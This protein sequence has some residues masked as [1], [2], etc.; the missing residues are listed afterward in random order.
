MIPSFPL[1]KFK[2]IVQVLVPPERVVL[3]V[4]EIAAALEAYQ[5]TTQRVAELEERRDVLLESNTREVVRRREAEA[6]ADAERAANVEKAERLGRALAEIERLKNRCSSEETWVNCDGLYVDGSHPDTPH[7]PIGTKRGERC[8]ACA[9]L[10]EL[11]VSRTNLKDA[12]SC[13]SLR[14]KRAVAAEDEVE[15]LRSENASALK[16]LEAARTERDAEAMRRDRA[17]DSLDAALTRAEK[18]DEENES[19]REILTDV[20]GDL[21]TARLT[22]EERT[23]ILMVH[24]EACLCGCP[25]SSHETYEEGWAC[26]DEGHTCVP[27][28][29]AALAVV[30]EIRTSAEEQGRELLAVQRALTEAGVPEQLPPFKVPLA[31]AIY[32]VWFLR[33]T[34]AMAQRLMAADYRLGRLA[35][36]INAWATATFPG[37]NERSKAEHLRREAAELAAKPTDTEEMAD[38]FILLANLTGYLGVDLAAAVEAKMAKNRKRKWGAPDAQGVVEHVRDFDPEVPEEAGS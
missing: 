22:I 34:V 24:Q 33:E 26:E 1:Q 9:A 2:E 15:R 29:P 21:V 37:T 36:E 14:W 35:R 17:E 38:V 32:R 25:P 31:P 27:V 5:A 20:A 28:C 8:P 16:E 18:L 12:L 13:G 19:L 7:P 10:D 4:G 11:D 6:R 23:A 30:N 3:P